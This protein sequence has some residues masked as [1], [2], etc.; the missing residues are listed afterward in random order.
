MLRPRP[1][2][3]RFTPLL[4]SVADAPASYPARRLEDGSL[5]IPI[6]LIRLICG[7]GGLAIRVVEEPA[8]ALG[9]VITVAGEVVVMEG[10]EVLIAGWE[11]VIV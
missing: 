4:T 8:A 10:V 1:E 7:G 9:L 2:D 3:K 6:G 5:L 11:E